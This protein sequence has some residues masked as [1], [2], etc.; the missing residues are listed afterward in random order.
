MDFRC[1]QSRGIHFIYVLPY[2][3]R[4]ALV[5]STM[6]SPK[7]EDDGFYENAIARYLKD[8]L[9][10]DNAMVLRREKGAIPMAELRGP[11]RRAQTIPIGA[12]GGAIR[13]S[14]GY[15]FSFIQKQISTLVKAL[16]SQSLPENAAPHQPIDLMMDRI[17]LKVIARRPALAPRIFAA[18][19]K[20][21]SGDEMA[22][23]MSGRATMGLRFKVVMAMPKWP[24]ILAF[25]SRWRGRS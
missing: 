3:D 19:G 14:S 18:M 2:S 5:E 20:A 17:F 10:V 9:G 12:R 7:I 11:E 21:L 25:L 15:A 1:D 6:F 22:I 16:S 24:F 8:Q 4:R 13:P 23:F